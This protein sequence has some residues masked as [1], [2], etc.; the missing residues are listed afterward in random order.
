MTEERV[1]FDGVRLLI[2]TEHLDDSSFEHI[3]SGA[4]VETTFDIAELHDLSSGGAFKISS[5]GAFSFAE[6][7]SKELIGSVGFDSNEIE[8]E[9]DGE[10]AATI[11]TT[12]HHDKR[13]RVQSD[14]TGTRLSNTRTALNS[15]ATM[16]QQAQQVAQSGSAAKMTEFFKSSSTSTRNYVAGVFSRIRSECASTSGGVSN[17]YCTDVYG[18]C[19]G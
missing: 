3:A 12:F 11:H 9:I 16:A 1:P 2:S 13:T 5:H 14:C 15:C 7:D 4:S 18:Y 17:W 6:G 19:S 8:A 10:A